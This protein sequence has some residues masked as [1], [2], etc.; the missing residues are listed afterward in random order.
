MQISHM[1]DSSPTRVRLGLASPSLR[2]FRDSRLESSSRYWKTR[3]RVRVFVKKLSPM[4][5]SQLYGARI[6]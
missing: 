3:T 6:Y 4:L 2:Y 1:K 5:C